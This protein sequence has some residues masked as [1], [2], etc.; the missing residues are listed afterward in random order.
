MN[1]KSTAK[2]IILGTWDGQIIWRYQTAREKLLKVI[3]ENERSQ[4]NKKELINGH[5]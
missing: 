4:V 1:N 3:F 2:K 5:K